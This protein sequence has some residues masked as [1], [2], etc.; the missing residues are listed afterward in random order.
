[1]VYILSISRS[2]QISLVITRPT[3]YR[4]HSAKAHVSYRFVMVVVDQLLEADLNF[5]SEQIV[6]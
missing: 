3:Y 6:L 4:Y 5:A 2:K 1:M